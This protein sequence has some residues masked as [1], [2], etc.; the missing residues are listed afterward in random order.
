MKLNKT[1]INKKGTKNMIYRLTINGEND[2]IHYN[3][4]VLLNRKNEVLKQW[5]IGNEYGFS[6]WTNK[7]K[8]I[9]NI[10]LINNQ[11]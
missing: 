10:A 11:K 1:L 8:P 9:F 5:T 4:N 3:R 2:M 6:F 7:P